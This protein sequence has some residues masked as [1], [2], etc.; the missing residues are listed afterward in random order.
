MFGFGFVFTKLTGNVFIF[1]T[2][3]ASQYFYSHFEGGKL[4]LNDEESYSRPQ[5]Y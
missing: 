1:Y 5:A 2:K 4:N 3:L